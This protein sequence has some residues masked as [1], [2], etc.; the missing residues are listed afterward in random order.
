MSAGSP[1]YRAPRPGVCYSFDPARLVPLAAW[2]KA[3]LGEVQQGR[4]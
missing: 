3:L 4:R 1:E 2:L